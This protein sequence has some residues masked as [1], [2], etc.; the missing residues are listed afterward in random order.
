MEVIKCYKIM[1][2]D[3]LFS[4]GGYDVT[5]TKKGK[6]WPSKQAVMAHLA[7]FVPTKGYRT[8]NPYKDT[9]TIVEMIV[10]TEEGSKMNVLDELNRLTT[11]RAEKDA[12]EEAIWASARLLRAKKD[13]QK[14]QDEVNKLTQNKG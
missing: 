2:K 11:N 13:L 14:A 7:L 8:K 1:N 5:W 10:S 4:K 9:D 12:K 3:G 6:V